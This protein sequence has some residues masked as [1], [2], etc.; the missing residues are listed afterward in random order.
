MCYILQKGWTALHHAAYNGHLE[1][2]T[3]LINSGCDINITDIVSHKKCIISDSRM[4]YIL[5]RGW[6]ALH[7]AAEKGHLAIVTLLISNGCD[8]NITNEVSHINV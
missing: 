6:T 1:I 2:V 3:L 8:I 4:C 7:K 5:Q